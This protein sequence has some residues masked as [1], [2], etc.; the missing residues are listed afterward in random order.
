MQTAV[1][2]TFSSPTLTPPQPSGSDQSRSE[3]TEEDLM[4]R[5]EEWREVA[6]Y[7]RRNVVQGVQTEQ[8]T[9][10]ESNC[11]IGSRTSC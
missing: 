4:K 7:L 5:I 9:F 10:S 6:V 2:Q 3:P 8:G 11:G 1:R